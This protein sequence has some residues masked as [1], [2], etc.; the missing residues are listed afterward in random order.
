[1]IDLNELAERIAAAKTRPARADE[2]QR[3]LSEVEAD[4][5]KTWDEANAA[6]SFKDAVRIKDYAEQMSRFVPNLYLT[7]PVPQG[8]RVPISKD[9]DSRIMQAAQTYGGAAKIAGLTADRLAANVPIGPPVASVEKRPEEPKEKERWWENSTVQTIIGILAY[10]AFPALGGRFKFLK[11]LL[12][13]L[14][15]AAG[16]FLVYIGLSKGVE[17]AGKEVGKK[18]PDPEKLAS[19]IG[20]F[21]ALVLGILLLRQK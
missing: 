14:S 10:V 18:L 9:W 1:M 17:A 5:K 21:V 6:S 16:L 15:K 7:V 20:A 19:S 3:V 12:K 4:A 11:P 2:E 8:E 13:I